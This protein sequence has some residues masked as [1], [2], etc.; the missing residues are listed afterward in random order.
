MKK[1]VWFLVAAIAVLGVA[2]FGAQNVDAYPQLGADCAASGCHDGVAHAKIGGAAPAPAKPATPAPAPTP[3]PAKPAEPAKPATPAAPAKTELTGEAKGFKSQVKVKVTLE[4]DKI[5]AVDVVSHDDTKGIADNAVNK[6]PGAIVAK[7]SADVDVA[8]G[9]TMTSKGIIA[10]VKDALA[11][12]PAAAKPTT[13]APA[14]AKP[15]APK[16]VKVD[17]KLFGQV[18]K[19]DIAVINGD[20]YVGVRSAVQA[21]AGKLDFD[22]ATKQVVVTAKGFELKGQQGHKGITINGKAFVLDAPVANVDGALYVQAHSAAK[23][24]GELAKRPL[25]VTLVK[26]VLELK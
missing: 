24:A 19:V 8:A 25:A 12:K 22:Q 10:A 5:T 18:G 20:V 16:A 4:G 2:A 21:A 26:N 23:I 7:Q 6:V 1:T 14:P 3:A 15:A 9:A 11:K 13:P 17:F